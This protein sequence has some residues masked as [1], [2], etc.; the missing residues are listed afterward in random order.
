MTTKK[1][2]IIIVLVV[3]VV[4]ILAYFIFSKPKVE[5]DYE[6]P[7]NTPENAI[8]NP[9]VN[10]GDTSIT[11]SSSQIDLNK[12]VSVEEVNTQK[13]ESTV[14]ALALSFTERIGSYSNQSN[15]QNIIELKPF[16][17][18]KMLVWADNFVSEQSGADNSEYFG[19]TT[20][21]LST[22]LL[23]L[24]SDVGQAKL[25]LNT[26]RIESKG[27][28]RDNNVKVQ[29]AQINLLKI[30]EKWFVDSLNWL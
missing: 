27:V 11:D 14:K 7:A 16:M 24:D 8:D 1:R 15:F 20:R 5:F 9:L 12:K 22:N 6:L 19:V 25:E 21:V 2:N 10:I 30:N 18:K 26:Q 4:L 23:S 17:T 13:K 28:E 3:L 29:K